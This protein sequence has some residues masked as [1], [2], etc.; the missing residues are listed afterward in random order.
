MIHNTTPFKMIAALSLTL[1]S[2]LNPCRAQERHEFPSWVKPAIES[3]HSILASDAAI[4]NQD[5]S[6][7]LTDNRTGF[8]GYIGSD[9]YKMDINFHVVR[10][11][12]NTTYRISGSSKVKANTCTFS[13][14]IRILDIRE[15]NEYEYGVDD[16]MKDRVKKQGIGIASYTLKE[17]EK[18]KGSGIFSGTLLFRWYIDTDNEVYYDGINDSAD[19][20]S[21]NQFAGVWRSYSTGKEKKCAWG[22]FRIPDSGDL[23][24]GAAEFSVNPIYA[25][26]GWNT[27]YTYIQPDA[28]RDNTPCYT[29]YNVIAKEA[30]A[31]FCLSINHKEYRIKDVI[32]YGD[33]DLKVY[34]NDKATIL[35]IGLVDYHG[36]TFFVYHFKDNALTRLGEMQVK[37]PDDVEENGMREISFKVY[38]AKNK[39]AIESYLDGTLSGK[40]EFN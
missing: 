27:E 2:F 21:N 29:S 8:I 9:Y 17:D 30:G 7:V 12:N 14:N 3:S 20:Y 18:Q 26:N 31:Y 4:L 28:T 10:K 32:D 40:K 1:L 5:F 37:Q 24:I 35:L 39:I 23:D 33:L 22:K 25:N 16:C 11:E 34:R 36:G 13:G 15:L 38:Q 19:S 6:V